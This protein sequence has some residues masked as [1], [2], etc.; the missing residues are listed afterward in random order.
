MFVFVSALRRLCRPALLLTLCFAISFSSPAQISANDPATNLI[1]EGLLLKSVGRIGRSPFHTDPIEEL[2]VR[3]AWKAPAEGQSIRTG[4]TN[5]EWT[6]I[7]ASPDG[8]FKD[9]GR[10]NSYLFTT[11]NAEQPETKLLDAAGDNLVYVNG[12]PRPGDPYSNGILELPV[13]L[14]KGENELLF[15]IGRGQLKASLVTPQAPLILI[16]RDPTLPDIIRGN[17]EDLWG[18]IVVANCTT[19]PAK[20]LRITSSFEGGQKVETE[21]PVVPA[22]TVRKVPFKIPAPP[23]TASNRVDLLLSLTRSNSNSTEPLHHGA[24]AL[25]IR[26]PDEH[27]KQT[28]RSGVDGSIQY[29]AVAPASPQN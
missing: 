25:R 22:V 7:Q 23:S 18:A 27:Y 14:H 2:I 15:Q 11:I 4:E 1:R 12:E 13:L 16:F 17:D 26:N 28:F 21:L 19:N 6:K 10:G 9:L 5:R 8:S 20:Q 3:G 29:F 24:L